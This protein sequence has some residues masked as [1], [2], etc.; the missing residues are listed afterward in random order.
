M[1]RHYTEVTVDHHNNNIVSSSANIQ[2]DKN[3]F[4]AFYKIA[5]VREHE[6]FKKCLHKD[7]RHIKP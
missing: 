7:N 4:N 6:N 3:L 5:R 1:I 2:L